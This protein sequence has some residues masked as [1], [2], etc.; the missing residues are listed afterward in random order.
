MSQAP[1]S[2]LGYLGGAR[3]L[4]DR[5]RDWVGR[6]PR[7]DN[8]TNELRTPSRLVSRGTQRL[9]K[10]VLFPVRFLYTAETGQVGTNI[11]AVAHYLADPDAPASSLVRAALTWR[12]QP[13]ADGEA[14]DL[15]SRELLSLYI[16]YIDDHITRLRAIHQ[17]PLAD[18]FNQWR[19][20]LLA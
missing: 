7:S 12:L 19:A 3:N 14:I 4:P 9:T 11:A 8:G 16:Y 5:L 20:R 2:L 1:N 13:P 17:V 6:R 10:V 18:S 15:L